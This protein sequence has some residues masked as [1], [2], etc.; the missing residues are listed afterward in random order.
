MNECRTLCVKDI[1]ANLDCEDQEDIGV[2]KVMG[3]M[4]ERCDLKQKDDLK[5]QKVEDPQESLKAV[6]KMTKQNF[7]YKNSRSKAEMQKQFLIRKYCLLKGG[8]S[9]M[10]QGRERLLPQAPPRPALISANNLGRFS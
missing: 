2:G 10:D 1:W 6:Q 7:P 4:V 9:K 3:E 5:G 8:V